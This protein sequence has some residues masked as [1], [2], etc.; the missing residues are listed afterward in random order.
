MHDPD[1]LLDRPPEAAVRTLAL[2]LLD[3]AAAAAGQLGAEGDGEA[4]HDFRVALRRLRTLF[5]SYRGLFLDSVSKKRMR[6]L[7]DL[8]GSTGGARDAE[9]QLEWLTAARERLEPAARDACSGLMERLESRRD[10]AYAAL[11]GDVLDRFRRLAARLRD[12]LSH[13]SAAVAP[14]TARVMFAAAVGEEV[15]RTGRELVAALGAVRSARDVEE[16]HEARIRGKR[17][18]YL[19]EP[20][21][22]TPL[23]QP[24]ERLVGTIKALQDVLGNLHDMHVLAAEI[25]TSLVEAAAERARSLHE[26]L[27][28]PD[29]A[30]TVADP[31]AG[32]MALDRLVRDRVDELFQELRA[33]W[34]GAQLASFAGEVE[35]LADA[36]CR[37]GNPAAGEGRHVDESVAR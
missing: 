14:D 12:G 18:R 35:A 22:D 4:L 30:A 21:R 25:A 7:R 6:A 33:G 20:L 28:S 34:E 5:R 24:A 32:I 11:R 37:H 2:R 17:L 27:Y 3:D 16:A 13:Y 19:V 23:A 15:R 1:A 31:S 10:A 36:L 29:A 8:A 9:V 26:S